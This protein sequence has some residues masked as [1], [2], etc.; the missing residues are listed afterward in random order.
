[1]DPAVR[2]K[3]RNR[4]L[5]LWALVVG[6]FLVLSIPSGPP[7]SP[8]AIF[9]WLAGEVA[10]A[11]LALPLAFAFSYAGYR[12]RVS[13]QER[14]QPQ[15]SSERGPP[16]SSPFRFEGRRWKPSVGILSFVLIIIVPIWLLPVPSQAIP[17]AMAQVVRWLGLAF[18]ALAVPAA[19]LGLRAV[20]YQIDDRGIHVRRSSCRG[21]LAGDGEMETRSMTTGSPTVGANRGTRVRPSQGDSLN[22]IRTTLI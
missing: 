2:R 22:W 21:T 6:P 4:A 20:T 17:N 15:L 13:R 8:A 7:P 12:L 14:M 1:M 3:I 5:L 9:F 10:A 19:F 18:A 11:L 16:G